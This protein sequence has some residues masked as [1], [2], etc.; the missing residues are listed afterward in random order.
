M[1]IVD[2]SLGSI[3]GESKGKPTDFFNALRFGIHDRLQQRRDSGVGVGRGV[4][5]WRPKLVLVEPIRFRRPRHSYAIGF[6]MITLIQAGVSVFGLFYID[7]ALL[8]FGMI[9]GAFAILNL[10]DKK[11]ID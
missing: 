6:P 9:F 2:L 3:H 1:I 5:Y 7:P 8:A 11:R 4:R 10:I